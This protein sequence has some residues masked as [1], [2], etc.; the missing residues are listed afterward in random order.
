MKS[1]ALDI[2]PLMG[3]GSAKGIS[4][5]LSLQ[6]LS[7]E[8][9]PLG[10]GMLSNPAFYSTKLRSVSLAGTDAVDDGAVQALSE[11]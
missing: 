6:E 2:C 1:L 5:L 8:H 7:L 9:C 4:G 10:S 11:R 3:D